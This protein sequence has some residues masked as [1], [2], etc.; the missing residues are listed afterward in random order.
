[1]CCPYLIIYA[2]FGKGDVDV[3]LDIVEL[4][5]GVDAESIY[6]S[7]MVYIKQEWMMSF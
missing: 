1:M 2:R 6:N 5:D 4:T 7:M 3:F